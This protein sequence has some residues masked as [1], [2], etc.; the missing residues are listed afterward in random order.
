MYSNIKEVNIEQL[1]ILVL[2]I[3]QTSKMNE[4]NVTS[5]N[6]KELES[7]FQA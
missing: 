4:L 7:A 3:N 1:S 5:W 2:K 6:I